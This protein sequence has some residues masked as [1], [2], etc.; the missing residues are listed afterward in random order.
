VFDERE[1]LAGHET[2]RAHRAV[3]LAGGGPRG[4]LGQRP[5]RSE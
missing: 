2:C 1:K 3:L 4:V 5:G